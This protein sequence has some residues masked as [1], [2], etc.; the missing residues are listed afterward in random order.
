MNIVDLTNLKT[1]VTMSKAYY[2]NTISLKASVCYM[3]CV[4]HV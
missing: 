4:E 1:K 3:T 2:L